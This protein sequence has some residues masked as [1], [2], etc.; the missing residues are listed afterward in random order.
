MAGHHEKELGEMT[1]LMTGVMG[2]VLVF[3][4]LLLV[5]V[6]FLPV[7]KSFGLF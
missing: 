5:Y 7:F 6:T 4:M 3:G 1:G 2:L